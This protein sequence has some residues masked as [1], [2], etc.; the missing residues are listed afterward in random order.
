MKTIGFSNHALEQMPDRGATREEVELTIRAGERTLAKGGRSTFRK[1]F[2]FQRVWK[3]RY[4]EIKQV[5]P[6]VV[7]ES[8]RI[9]VVTVYT[10]YFGEKT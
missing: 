8:D 3:G 2:S 7:E 5:M 6:V 4:Y 10:F 1:N 9:V